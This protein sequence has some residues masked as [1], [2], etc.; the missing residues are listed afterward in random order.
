MTLSDGTTSVTIVDANEK[1]APQIDQSW[2]SAA[3]GA[4]KGQTTGERFKLSVNLVATPAQYRSLINLL[5][6]N[7]EH[8]YYTPEETY[9]L[10][11]DTSFPIPVK[12]SDVKETWD[13]RS[14][15]YI[16]FKIESEDYI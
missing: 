13:N 5:I 12:I 10:Y 14:A 16:K 9:T 15:Y 6:S 11:S 4:A 7:P 2:K 8:F 3:S 1:T